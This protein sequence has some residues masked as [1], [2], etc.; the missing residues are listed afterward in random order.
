MKPADD[1]T[2]ACSFPDACCAADVTLAEVKHLNY[3]YFIVWE[4]YCICFLIF[5]LIMQSNRLVGLAELRCRV[6]YVRLKVGRDDDMDPVLQFVCDIVIDLS[7]VML[8][9]SSTLLTLV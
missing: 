8:L 2:N 4:N 7:T 5:C 3:S 6:L 9:K 1:D